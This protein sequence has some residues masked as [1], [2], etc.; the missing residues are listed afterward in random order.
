MVMMNI[1]FGSLRLKRILDRSWYG[2]C[3]Y[4]NSITK[5]QDEGFLP[6]SGSM[7]LDYF[8]YQC[9][10]LQYLLKITYARL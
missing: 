5:E 10:I 4:I 3:I 6:R 8:I 1:D 9:T 7:K 2:N